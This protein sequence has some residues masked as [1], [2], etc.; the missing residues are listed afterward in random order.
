MVRRA[1]RRCP[2]C[3]V[4]VVDAAT[5]DLPD[6][7]PNS[8]DVVLVSDV[9]YYIPFAGVPQMVASENSNIEASRP[10]FAALANLARR[11]VVFSAHQN[12]PRVQAILRAAGARQFH[13]SGAWVLAGTAPAVDESAPRGVSGAAD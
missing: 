5:L 2:Q 6:G 9:L 8:Y 11:E 13:R 7:W 4:A 12:N 1:R 3:R 10:W